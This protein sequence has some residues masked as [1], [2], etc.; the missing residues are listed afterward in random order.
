MNNRGKGRER[1][2]W[3]GCGYKKEKGS[4]RQTGWKWESELDV[5]ANMVRE[6]QAVQSPPHLTGSWPNLLQWLIRTDCVWEWERDREIQGKRD[7]V[8]KTRNFKTVTLPL[9][10]YSLKSHYLSLIFSDHQ[11]LLY[12][13]LSSHPSS[14]RRIYA[15]PNP[16]RE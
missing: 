1:R 10:D 3:A 2:R 16:L 4:E 8:F 13:T 5:L 9:T 12:F 15:I 11:K 7:T 14:F 6:P